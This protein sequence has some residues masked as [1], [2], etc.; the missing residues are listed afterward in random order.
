MTT[1]ESEIRRLANGSIDTAWY[2]RHC[3]RQ[4]SLAVHK[5]IAGIFAAAKRAFTGNRR[6]VKPVSQ[7]VKLPAEPFESHQTERA[8]RRAA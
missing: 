6:S 2:V 7:V 8:D 5:A 4:R 1:S 3:H